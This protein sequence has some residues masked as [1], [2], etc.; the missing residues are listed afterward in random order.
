M[1]LINFW[2][3]C[4]LCLCCSLLAAHCSLSFS[5]QLISGHD[6]I[7]SG[8]KSVI[9]LDYL[10]F[11]ETLEQD[12]EKT[13]KTFRSIDFYL[14]DRMVFRRFSIR[15][16]RRSRQ[17][18]PEGRQVRS[19]LYANFGL[20]LSRRCGQERPGQAVRGGA[21][22]KTGRA[23]TLKRPTPLNRNVTLLFHMSS[24]LPSQLGRARFFA[25]QKKALVAMN[26][27]G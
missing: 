5:F 25:T 27:D 4:L 12:H 23:G 6:D 18:M 8:G 21:N 24:S 22:T 1:S 13:R 17:E 9:R 26:D 14:S 16:H 20:E 3:D 11:R 15:E 19:R 7:G 2:D 10:F